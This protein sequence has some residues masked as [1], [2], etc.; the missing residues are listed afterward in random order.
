[1]NAVSSPDLGNDFS[2]ITTNNLGSSKISCFFFGLSS[3]FI[4]EYFEM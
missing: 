3:G 4:A 1:M 2:P